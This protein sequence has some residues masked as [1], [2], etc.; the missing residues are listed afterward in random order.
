MKKTIKKEVT[1]CDNCE[2]ETYVEPCLRC[3]VE[4]CWKCKEIESVEYGHAVYFQG[5]GDGYYCKACDE[6]L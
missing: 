6:F 4:H 1:F 3:G 2:K 5:S